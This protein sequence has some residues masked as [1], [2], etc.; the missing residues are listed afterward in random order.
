[1]PPEN[2]HLS[3]TIWNIIELFYD[4][5]TFSKTNVLYLYYFTFYSKPLLFHMQLGIRA[6]YKGL[7][8]AI[9]RCFPANA[10][11]FLAYEGTERLLK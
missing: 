8:P 6:L 7:G 1:M 3:N 5:K 4:H 11:L 9:L 10:A 2:D